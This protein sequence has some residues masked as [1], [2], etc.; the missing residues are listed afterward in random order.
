MQSGQKKKGLY[1]SIYDT[2][3]E[4]DEAVQ[5]L[6][7]KLALS[8]ES[9]TLELKKIF[10]EGTENWDNLLTERAKISGELILSSTLKMPLRKSKG[11]NHVIS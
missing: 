10:W 5:K 9:A 8:H 1:A 7:R 6:C 4:M 11:N 2:T 3:E